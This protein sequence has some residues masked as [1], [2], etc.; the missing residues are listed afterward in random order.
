MSTPRELTVPSASVDP[1]RTLPIVVHMDDADT[2]Y[3]VV[4]ALSLTPF[5]DGAQ[6]W[7][8]TARLDHIRPDAS[9]LPPG[10]VPVRQAAGDRREAL[11]ATGEGWTLRAVRWRG[12]GGE[13]TVTAISDEL[14][15]S[16]LAS[17]TSDAA[18]T[19][20]DAEDGAVDLGFWYHS[21]R[22][23]GYRTVRSVDAPSWLDIRA[24]YAGT[25]AA[26]LDRVMAFRP[27]P[28]TGRLM[29]MHGEPGTGKTTALRSLA[30]QWHDWCQVD[31][32][33]DPEHLFADPG[34]LMDVVL[35]DGEEE[36]DGRW[37]L[38]LLE[39]CDELIRGDAKRTSGQAL[40]RLLNLTDG[41][42]GQSRRVLVAITT[43]ED[44]SRLHP[45]VTRPGRC[46]ARVEIGA[47]PREEATRWLGGAGE[48]GP[49]GATLAEL[50]ALRDG[51]DPVGVTRAA[52]PAGGFY[53]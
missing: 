2:T 14:A 10:A 46:L 41:L 12:G 45:A 20:V 53:L 32:V 11:L 15:R 43:N 6:P 48:V 42:L 7:A 36:D 51:A 37:R 47:L 33:L 16:V 30:R 26:A 49:D 35:G 28:T 9:L 34:Y 40:A 39:D 27:G 44:L 17:A 18:S 50:F 21:A 22:R 23:G 5:A 52:R 24:N 29:L 3:D 4:D 19:P 8:R 13:V 31:C 1:V 25:V 38:L